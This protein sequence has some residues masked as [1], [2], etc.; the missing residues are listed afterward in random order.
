MTRRRLGDRAAGVLDRVRRDLSAGDHVY[1][2]AP[3]GHP[4][5]GDEVL[6]RTWLRTLARLCPRTRVVV[7]CHTPGQAALLHA[8]AHPDVVFT[9]TV[10]RLVAEVAHGPAPGPDSVDLVRRALGDPGLRPALAAGVGALLGA[11][12]VHV[13]GGGF[14]NA[15]WPHHLGVFT[16]AAEAARR[17]GARAVAT[18]QGL[19][20]VGESVPLAELLDG[21]ELVTVRD[22]ASR[23]ATGG[24]AD[25]VG[26]DAWLALSDW[27]RPAE[28]YQ[29]D[30]DV[31]RD[32][33]LCLQ[34]DLGDVDE[35]T[36]L[37]ARTLRSWAVPG[38]QI[39]VIEGIPGADR[40]VWDRLVGSPTGATLRLEDARFVSFH[41]M[42][43]VGLPARAGQ[44]W[45]STR[46]HPH[47][48]AAAAGASGVAVA[49]DPDYYGIKHGSLLTAG[50]RWSV[51]AVGDGDPPAIPVDGGFPA[52][53]VAA[54][55]TAAEAVA[56]AVYRPARAAGRG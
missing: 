13:I 56:A 20:P 55:V 31:A 27:A 26:D 53:V 24:R 37:A 21:F 19:A 36:A 10:W 23:D 4:N 47:L 50:S 41:E 30:P 22:A 16:A 45:L 2:L 39:T 14:V 9:D 38:E 28:L 48:L 3:S 7:D 34:S 49:V 44:A 32:V 17:G 6:L 15:H 18:G 40:V 43:R 42:W 29:S 54:R 25:L 52:D 5:Y 1:L 11:S 33:V 8:G 12:V 51:V 46:F 35:V